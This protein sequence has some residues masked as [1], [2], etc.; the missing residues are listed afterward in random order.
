MFEH[1]LIGHLFIAL[2]LTMVA[3][4]RRHKIL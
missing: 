1:I 2:A 3:M 4:M